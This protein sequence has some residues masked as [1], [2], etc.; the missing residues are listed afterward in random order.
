MPFFFFFLNASALFQQAEKRCGLRFP[1][2]LA[3]ERHSG[4]EHHLWAAHAKT[5]VRAGT[6][7]DKRS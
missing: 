3:A 5:K 7:D 1:E 2:A 4:G 6:Q